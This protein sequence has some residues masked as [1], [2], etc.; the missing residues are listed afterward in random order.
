MIIIN[1]EIYYCDGYEFVPAGITAEE[2]FN[3]FSNTEE[4]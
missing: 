4:V 3:Q 1:G 2:F